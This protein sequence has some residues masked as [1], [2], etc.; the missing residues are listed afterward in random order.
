MLEKE[1][2]KKDRHSERERDWPNA[3]YTRLSNLINGVGGDYIGIH[4]F[5]FF[6]SMRYRFF[7]F[8]FLSRPVTCCAQLVR[9]Y[10]DSP[11]HTTAAA[12]ANYTHACTRKLHDDDMGKTSQGRIA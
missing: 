6:F 3:G 1:R 11:I 10:G 9:Y 7:S 12:A 4:Y 2:D 5:L 8:Y